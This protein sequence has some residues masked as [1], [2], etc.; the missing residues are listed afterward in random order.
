MRNTTVKTLP[1]I[2]L[3]LLS[4]PG[5]TEK[6]PEPAAPT[7]RPLAT[8][9]EIFHAKRIVPQPPASTI[10]A[11]GELPLVYQ[12]GLGGSVKLY[13]ATART[14]LWSAT[15]GP[16]SIIVV[17]ANGVVVRGVRVLPGRLDPDR[18]YELWFEP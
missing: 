4:S 11:A 6:K 15:V 1:L 16:G 10:L 12:F 7:S 9:S 14:Q 2:L 3:V 5:C 13:D 17:D 18:R 8:L